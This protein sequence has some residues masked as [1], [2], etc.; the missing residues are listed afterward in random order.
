MATSY[1]PKIITDGLALA[2]DAGDVKSYPGTGTTWKD[3][4]GSDYTGTLLNGAVFNSTDKTI[5][6]DGTDEGIDD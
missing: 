4:S 2:L 3:R 6:L 1:S 5:E